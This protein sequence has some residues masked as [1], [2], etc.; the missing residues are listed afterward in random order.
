MPARRPGSPVDLVGTVL[1][2]SSPASDYLT[3]QVIGVDGGF[4]AGGSWVKDE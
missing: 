1:L 3:G 2:L 4:L